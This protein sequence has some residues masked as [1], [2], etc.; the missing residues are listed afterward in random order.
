MAGFGG[1][2]SAPGARGMALSGLLGLINYAQ[3]APG[4]HDNTED[5]P[6]GRREEMGRGPLQHQ[7]SFSFL[8][9]GHP[10]EEHFG[11]PDTQKGLKGPEKG[12]G[13]G[14]ALSA[15]PTAW[16]YTPPVGDGGLWGI[17][18]EENWED[19]ENDQV[20]F[21]PLPPP[22]LPEASNM[23]GQQG[24]LGRT[25][26]TVKG[27]MSPKSLGSPGGN[28]QDQNLPQFRPDVPQLRPK[29]KGKGKGDHK[30]KLGRALNAARVLKSRGLKSPSIEKSFS[31]ASSLGAKNA[32]KRTVAKILETLAGGT[33]FLPLSQEMLK[34]LASALQEGG[35]KAGEGYL[36]EAKLW[37]I[38]KGHP[39]SDALDRAFKQCKR[40]LARG[41][42]P[43][44]RA[45]EVPRELRAHPLKLKFS[46]A[47]KAV[48]FGRELFVFATAWM[49]REIELAGIT[50]EDLMMDHLSKKVTLHLRMSKTDSEG[51]GVRRTLQCLCTGKCCDWECPYVLSKDLVEKVEGFNGTASALTLTKGKK[52]A[53]K[54]QIVKTWRHLFGQGVSGHSGRRTGALHYIRSGWAISQ[55]AHL[56]RWKSS[57]VLAYAEEA[58]EQ[59]PA[60]LHAPCPT[61]DQKG[62]QVTE[63]KFI[64]E[65]ELR[66]WKNLLQKEIKE[67][68]AEVQEKHRENDAQ[69]DNWAKIYKENP[70]TLPRKLQSLPSKVIHWNLARS[71]ASPPITWRTACGWSYY[72]SNFTFTD[73]DVELSHPQ[74]TEDLHKIE[75]GSAISTQSTGSNEVKSAEDSQLHAAL[76]QVEDAFSEELN[77]LGVSGAESRL[78]ERLEKLLKAVLHRESVA[79]ARLK[80]Q[81]KLTQTAESELQALEESSQKVLEDCRMLQARVRDLEHHE[82]SSTFRRQKKS[83]AILGSSGS[84]KSSLGGRFL[85][86]CGGVP[87]L[88]FKW[89]QEAAD[90]MGKSSQVYAFIMDWG[91]ACAEEERNRGLTMDC[92]HKLLTLQRYHYTW[93]DVPGHSDFRKEMMIGAAE[94]DCALILVPADEGVNPETRMICQVIPWLLSPV[95]KK[96]AFLVSKMDVAGYSQSKYDQIV[97]DIKNLLLST[98]GWP[99]KM[100]DSIPILPVAALHNDNL[101]R[102]SHQ[103]GW[104]TGHSLIEVLDSDV[105]KVPQRNADA[106]LRM[107]VTKVYQEKGIGDVVQGRVL[108][109]LC[110]PGDDMSFV[111]S[112]KSAAGRVYSAEM[113]HEQVEYGCP[114]DFLHANIKGFNQDDL[115]VVGDIMVCKGDT[116]KE[117]TGFDAGIQVC[118]DT[119]F[120]VGS[121]VV[122]FAASRFATC[123][124]T[125]LQWKV[126]KETG[127]KKVPNPTS[128][129]FGESA[130][131][132]FQ[133]LQPFVCEPMGGEQHLMKPIFFDE[134]M[135]LAMLGHV[136]SCEQKDVSDI[137]AAFKNF[138]KDGSGSISKTE[139]TDVLK[140]L[141]PAW[142]EDSLKRLMANADANADGKLQTQEFVNWIFSGKDRDDR[143]FDG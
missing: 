50:T 39:W 142:N 8:L 10:R 122:A 54:D 55:V 67:L 98:P 19:L 116:L 96:V 70:G 42:G 87:D 34:G 141:D 45:A 130:L 84:G 118:A 63:Q 43:K 123:K 6:R 75:N 132:S 137:L 129:K 21:P 14:K 23:V 138:D 90:A 140:E 88:N 111:G 24:T 47:D 29:V 32:K 105:F 41:Q 72:G 12:K 36:I 15:D 89:F 81:R 48:K 97:G 107:T 1:S 114:G 124:I 49:L 2:W 104:W 27:W 71:T 35:Y 40:A 5:H 20:G 78:H 92:K 112:Y 33:E 66:N 134:K 93:I 127:G 101:M 17:P 74:M 108:Q 73:P 18:H 65:E 60:N 113:H 38:E 126:G 3:G 143:D 25:W 83:V 37:H 9:A 64:S 57:A 82:T 94:A 139:L 22:P 95:V 31:A 59:L 79:E 7:S 56:G 62:L 117:A 135:D 4:D 58:L 51:K 28:L 121:T 110:K 128:V 100:V 85:T 11:E 44:K 13:K 61:L 99:R 91:E 76:A 86:E 16:P 115:P 103:M 68:K 119:E 120:Q 53:T 109:G 125:A 136:L 46:Q 52:L 77:F 133:P 69:F 80:E 106:P 131:C 30:F 26:A 102:A